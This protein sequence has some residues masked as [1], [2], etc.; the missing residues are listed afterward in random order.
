M[1]NSSPPNRAGRALR[2][3]PRA[4]G[5]DLAQ[6]GV[7]GGVAEA[8][9]HGAEAVDV[10]EQQRERPAAGVQLLDALEHGGAV[11][12]PGHPIL[13]RE[14]LELLA[15]AQLVG[16]VAER[17]HDGAALERLRADPEMAAGG[18]RGPADAHLDVAPRL[19]QRLG[20]RGGMSLGPTG[21]M[22]SHQPGSSRVSR[23]DAED[24]Q[25]AGVGREHLTVGATEI[26]PSDRTPKT[27]CRCASVGLLLRPGHLRPYSSGWQ[28]FLSGHV[29]LRRRGVRRSPGTARGR[30]PDPRDRAWPAGGGGGIAP[31]PSAG[32]RASRAARA[33]LRPRRTGWAPRPGSAAAVARAAAII[34]GCR[35]R[36]QSRPSVRWNAGGPAPHGATARTASSSGRARRRRART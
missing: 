13:V 26:T 10:D 16:A 7:A 29:S 3:A 1:R 18:V 12:Q 20:R 31:T 15:R 23:V 8:T 32:Q 9:V 5:P 34:A 24:L 11:G 33:S 30:P 21:R 25:R 35:R 4:A 2:A 19:V 17:Q 6:D 27:A 14:R 22:R 36:G 28:E